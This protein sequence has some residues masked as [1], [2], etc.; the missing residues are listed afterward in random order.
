VPA[1]ARHRWQCAGAPGAKMCNQVAC[2]QNLANC[3]AGNDD[4]CETDLRTTG[5]D[6]GACGVRCL[7]GSV[8]S[9]GQCSCRAN[10]AVECPSMQTCHSNSVCQCTNGDPLVCGAAFSCASNKCQ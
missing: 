10:P 9:Q 4:T 2:A 1:D 8:C 7:T 5:T 6:C 3:G